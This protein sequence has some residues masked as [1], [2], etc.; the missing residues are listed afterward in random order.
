MKNILRAVWAIAALSLILA[1]SCSKKEEERKAE[2]R[3][4]AAE[5][6]AE[7]SEASTPAPAP[8]SAPAEAPVEAVESPAAET[9]AKESAPAPSKTTDLAA[10]G[11]KGLLP[12]PTKAPSQ[13]APA[14]SA[15][16]PSKTAAPAPANAP[17][18]PAPAAAEGPKP[19]IEYISGP[20][21]AHAGQ[22]LTLRCGVSGVSA[23]TSYVWSFKNGNDVIEK[24]TTEPQVRVALDKTG[25]YAIICGLVEAG[26]TLATQRFSI[27][28]TRPA[29]PADTACAEVCPEGAVGKCCK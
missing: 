24:K 28:V 15:K 13:T 25:E 9:P 20:K 27:R 11:V 6:P 7:V 23:A 10:D 22:E 4:Q 26:R 3:A 16:T 2:S 29:N 17:S 12:A 8:E 14:A 21:Q 19:V 5:E 1:V 18:Q